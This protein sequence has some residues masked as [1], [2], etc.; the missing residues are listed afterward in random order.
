MRLLHHVL[1]MQR[2][3]KATRIV[4]ILVG[5][6]HKPP[7]NFS[8]FRPVYGVVTENSVCAWT[9]LFEERRLQL[10]FGSYNGDG[11]DD[12]TGT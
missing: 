8:V 10:P 11:V 7:I 3:P 12:R 2:L 4:C 6:A 9:G 5:T 1:K